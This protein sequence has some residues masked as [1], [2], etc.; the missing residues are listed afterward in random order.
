MIFYLYP[1]TCNLTFCQLVKDKQWLFT[2]DSLYC[3]TKVSLDYSFIL[4]KKI[5]RK[6]NVIP[7]KW[8]AVYE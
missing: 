7:F 1:G 3:R 6:M 2:S 4:S 8:H 5:I